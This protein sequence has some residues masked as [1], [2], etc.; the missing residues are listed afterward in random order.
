M[1]GTRRPSRN[2]GSPSRSLQRAVEGGAG[3]RTLDQFSFGEPLGAP[4]AAILDRT[5]R[6]LRSRQPDGGTPPPPLLRRDS[7]YLIHQPVRRSALLH[8]RPG[9]NAR[10]A[11]L[12]RLP[13]CGTCVKPRPQAPIP[14]HT[15]DASRARPSVDGTAGFYAGRGPL[16]KVIFLILPPRLTMRRGRSGDGRARARGGDRCCRPRERAARRHRSRKAAGAP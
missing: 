13:E 2:P 6:S 3:R 1:A 8:R 9:R 10:R 11:A 4:R 15:N 7:A 5:C 12:V 14:P 16:V